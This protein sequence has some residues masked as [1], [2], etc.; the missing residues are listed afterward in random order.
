MA[1]KEGLGWLPNVVVVAHGGGGGGGVSGIL[2]ISM[3]SSD[4]PEPAQLV[5][6]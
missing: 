4:W 1:E 3:P 6:G 5:V 2:I